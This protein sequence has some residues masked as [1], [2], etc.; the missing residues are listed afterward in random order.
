MMFVLIG[1][2]LE[3]LAM[4]K[5][6][7]LQLVLLDLLIKSDAIIHLFFVE[8]SSMVLFEVLYLAFEFAH[9]SFVVVFPVP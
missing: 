7:D 2:G 6:T 5:V 9:C 8:L 3:M 1:D 4:L